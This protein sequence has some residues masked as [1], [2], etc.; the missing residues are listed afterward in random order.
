MRTTSNGLFLLDASAL[1]ALLWRAHEAHER[2]RRWFDHRG[3][4]GWAT[5][6]FTQS[7]FVRIVS[8]PAFSRDSLTPLQALRV[9][10]ANLE[11]PG[12]HFWPADLQLKEALGS[13][14]QRLT[15][16]QQVTD[17]YLFGLALQRKGKL[18]TLDRRIDSLLGDVAAGVVETIPR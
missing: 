11:H 10:Q 13:F 17:A 8:N 12:H 7:A 4:A 3:S 16:H 1:I 6:P 2:M 15:G 5:C 14:H 9:L 18:A